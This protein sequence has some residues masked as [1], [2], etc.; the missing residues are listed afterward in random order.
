MKRIRE[1]TLIAFVLFHMLGC[2]PTIDTSKDRV[3]EWAVGGSLH[4]VTTDQ[5]VL[6]TEADKRATAGALLY[7]AL[8]RGHLQSN[9]E[10][11]AFGEKAEQLVRTMDGM[12]QVLPQLIQTDPAYA[13][14]TIRS[15]VTDGMRDEEQFG[16]VIGPES[17]KKDKVDAGPG[18]PG[19][20]L[21]S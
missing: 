8:W 6:G 18:R 5:W 17:M 13:Y 4:D 15:F 9:E 19:T 7:E 20:G 1:T 16:E 10:L 12:A 3:P 2:A 21:A 11:V 14:L